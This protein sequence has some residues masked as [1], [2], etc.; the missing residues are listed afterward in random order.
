MTFLFQPTPGPDVVGGVFPATFPA[1]K[2]WNRSGTT[3]VKGEVVQ[4]AL[5]PGIATEA[6][7]NDSNSYRP[8]GSNDTIWNTV[9]L[10]VASTLAVPQSGIITGGIFGVVTSDSVAD[11]GQVD[12][13]FGGLVNAF[14]IDGG[15]SKDGALPGQPLTV[16]TAKNFDCDVATNE[17]L[18][19][20]YVGPTDT[21]LTNRDIKRVLLTNGV[22]L[23]R[24][25]DAGKANIT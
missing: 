20:F 24:H 25:Q 11:N 7:S 19:G 15:S 4:L 16:T 6:A 12:V 9:V 3:L 1:A 14:V 22:G 5:T 23:S 18:V 17:V 2:F 8:S 13:V 10:P 21:T